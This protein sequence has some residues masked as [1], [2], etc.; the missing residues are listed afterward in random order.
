MLAAL[1]AISDSFHLES[2]LLEESVL[3]SLANLSFIPTTN[4]GR[5][6]QTPF[7]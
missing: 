6:V 1:L 4:D 7:C 5:L 3:A 2:L